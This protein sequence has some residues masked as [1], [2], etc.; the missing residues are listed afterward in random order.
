MSWQKVTP[1]IRIS[2]QPKSCAQETETT[3]EPH[4]KRP[5]YSIP[6]LRPAFE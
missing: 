5:G 2:R 6:N 1:S 4:P 3:V